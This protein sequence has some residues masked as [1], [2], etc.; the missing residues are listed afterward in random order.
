[1]LVYKSSERKSEFLFCEYVYH[2]TDGSPGGEMIST[3]SPP[4]GRGREGADAEASSDPT[5]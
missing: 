3:G 1:M 5:P 2:L 4:T